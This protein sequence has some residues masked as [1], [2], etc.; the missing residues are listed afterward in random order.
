VN[1]NRRH[2]RVSG[3]TSLRLGPVLLCS[4]L[5]ALCHVL[6]AP[7]TA[8]V[9]MKEPPEE[10]RG[11]GL[12]QKPGAQVPLN[13]QFT[14]ST[15]RLVKLE[16]YFNQGKPV[17]LS[18]VYYDCP[19]ICPLTLERL[20]ERLN[21]VAYTVGSD[22]TML[23]ISFDPTNT[24]QQAANQKLTYLTGY[25]KPLTP[26]VEAGWEYFTSDVSNVR[27]LASSVGFH[28]NYIPESGE[29]AHGSALIVLTPDGRVSRYLDGL[30]SDGHELRLALL[31]A[32]EGKIAKGLADF[33][34]HRCF[35][36]DPNKNSY[37]LHAFR[38]MQMGGILTA[39]AVFTLLVGLR[40]G[41]R[42]RAAKRAAAA[43]V[44]GA[45]AVSTQGIPQARA[46]RAG[47]RESTT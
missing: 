1:G 11:V 4:L 5:L 33:F 15:G 26:E 13:L 12:D 43:T 17:V 25:N 30:G 42:A 8:Q 22:F 45:G 6:L 3:A 2:I 14:S 35:K 44:E 39:A 29:Y 10:L 9:L 34:L 37:T 18:L 36:W 19:M 47:G 41:E 31:E 27:M 32:S 40:A 20:Q 28:Y 16:S 7:A 46:G 21:A 38:V 23:V 24:T